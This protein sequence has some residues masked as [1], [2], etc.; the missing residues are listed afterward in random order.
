MP[1]LSEITLEQLR[2]YTK[3]KII[4][5]ITT[6]LNGMTKRKLIMFL[7]DEIQEMQRDP[8]R[9][10]RADGQ[11]ESQ[12]EIQEDIETGAQTGK[13]TTAWTYYPTGEVDEITISNY[14]AL[15]GLLK[16]KIIKHYRDGKQPT[17]TEE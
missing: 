7:W 11:I 3:A 6:K 1:L 5:W 15:D 14:D 13:R 2:S 4:N 12:A 16:R 10:Y 17:V 9:T 8:I